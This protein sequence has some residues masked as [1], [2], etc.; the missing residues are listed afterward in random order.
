MLLSDVGERGV[1]EDSHHRR[2]DVIGGSD[3]LAG[4]LAAFDVLQI[5]G[6]LR[7][8]GERH[9]IFKDR[10]AT[11]AGAGARILGLP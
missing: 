9:A 5:L 4:Q 2:R 1:V 6:G 7:D 10:R 8:R 3:F 11:S